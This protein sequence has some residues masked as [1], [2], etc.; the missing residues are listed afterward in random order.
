MNRTLPF[1][2]A[3]LRDIAR[4]HPTPFHLYD[5]RAI[6]GNARRF[7][8]AFAWNQGFRQ[9]FAVKAT[10]T[11]AIVSLL[12]GLG[13]GMDCSSLAELELCRRLGIAGQDVM[14]TS[15]DTAA[16]EFRLAARMGAIVNLDDLSHIDFLERAAGL[17]R[18]LCLRYN[19]GDPAI[20]NAIIGTPCQAKFGIPRDQL[21]QG[22]ALL[23]AKGVQR[24]GLHTMVVSNELNSDAFVAVAELMF[25]LAVAVRDR[26]GVR[27][28]FI[29]LGGGLGI[30]YRPEQRPIDV[31]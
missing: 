22:Y 12:H 23:A 1:D 26:T 3:A 18:T 25:E 15:N 11:P 5:E 10:P 8:D 21:L 19:P 7:L 27:V 9:Y 16:A 24:F 31:G 13:M 28:D 14:F 29:N 4:R 6:A 20:G 2:T 30:P 17:P